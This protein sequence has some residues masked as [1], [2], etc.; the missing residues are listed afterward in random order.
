MAACSTPPAGDFSPSDSCASSSGCAVSG[1][2]G[3]ALTPAAKNPCAGC[4]GEAKNSV[5]AQAGEA[6][7]GK[8]PLRAVFMG[9]PGFAAAI[10]QRVLEAGHVQVVAAYTQPDRPAGRGK[11]LKAPEVKVL[12]EERGIPVHQPLNFK[13]TADGDA[14][15]ATLAA[16]QPDVLIVA[17]YGLILPQRVLNIPR[18]MPINVH[19]SLLPKYRGA[20]PIQRA[21]IS[22]D[23]VT[24]ITIMRMEAGLDTG[25]ILM[26]RAV[27]IDLNDTSATL[28]D[29]LA[30]EGGELL[31]LA[32]ERLSGGALHAIPQ[33][34]AR[35][36]HA[37]KLSKEEGSLDFTLSCRALH[38]HI[39]GI[40]PWPGA[41][42]ILHRKG[43]EDA[44]IQVA[45]GLF[46]L[47]VSMQE[48]AAVFA[49]QAGGDRETPGSG[50]AASTSHI[51]GVVEGALLISCADGCYAF[52]S[53]RP[54]GR[55][56]MDGRA[57]FNGYLAGHEDIFF[58]G[59]CPKNQE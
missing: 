5:Q 15:V 35:A 48:A 43:Q 49:Q 30:R 28:H 32:L 6:A 34:N 16:Y 40:T 36:T 47:P 54:A 23:A 2:Q 9:T 51:I 3:N 33:D 7:L 57:F 31:I 11:A 14:A 8:P 29:E 27:G 42:M 13:A 10:L 21:I 45:P 26:Q 25:P 53:L 39:R 24:G 20:A 52:T 17:A 44:V 56:A 46:P 19:A 1:C 37:A 50:A 58:S 38:A 18:L 55:K 12:A 4:S 22:G 59:R 41:S